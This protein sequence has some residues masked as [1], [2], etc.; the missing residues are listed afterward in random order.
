[1]S[2]YKQTKNKIIMQ[3][4]KTNFSLFTSLV[5][6]SPNSIFSDAIIPKTIA[7][8]LNKPLSARNSSALTLPILAKDKNP[9]SE[10]QKANFSLSLDPKTLSYHTSSLPSQIFQK[11]SAKAHSH[12]DTLDLICDNLYISGENAASDL[13]SLKETGITH[14]INMNAGSSPINFPDAFSY[15]S[16][17]L[18]DS[19]FEVLDEEFWK[20]VEFLNQ[21][22]QKGGTVLVHCR[23]GIS[24][25]AALC[26]AYLLKYK[27]MEFE[28]AMNL[29]KT[30][31][32][33]VNI[34]NG[35]AQQIIQYTTKTKA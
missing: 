19:V 1:M 7:E 24:R 17:R 8:A 25:S 26:L 10:K 14:I 18:N 12:I 33:M 27:D 2:E 32:P 30:A 5:D 6:I 22:I 11:T 16:V 13:T 20:A 29:I 4:N 28:D 23:K 9:L 35:F 34:N 31:R 3:I 15:Y 21:T